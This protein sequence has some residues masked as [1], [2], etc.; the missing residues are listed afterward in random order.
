M[1]KVFGFVITGAVLMS[2][3]S[4]L[5]AQTWGNVFKSAGQAAVQTAVQQL[6][7]QAQTAV[8]ESKKLGTGAPQENFLLTKAKEFLAAGNYQPAW[9]LANY[10]I[11][12]VNSKSIDAP[13]ILADAKAALTKIAQEKLA[14]TQQAAAVAQQGQA[15][16]IAAQQV[17]ADATQT[18]NS[19]KNL[20]GETK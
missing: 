4:A 17:Q 20:F 15:S 10:V 9:D 2:A 18:G 14:Q 6:T 5:S 11:T 7:P 13:K 19:I 3:A 1:K 12:T 8:H 16:T